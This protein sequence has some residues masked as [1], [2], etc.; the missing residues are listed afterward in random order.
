MEINNKDVVV[1]EPVLEAQNIIGTLMDSIY[2]DGIYQKYLSNLELESDVSKKKA[3]IIK[4]TF[5]DIQVFNSNTEPLFLARDIGILMGITNI[6]STIKNYNKTEKIIGYIIQKGIP[7]EKQLLTRYGVY[8]ILFNS[9]TKLSELFRG[10]IYKLLDHM[11]QHE[12]DKL[13]TII[14]DYSMDNQDL[15]KGSI[16][17]LYENANQF[18]MLYENEKRERLIWMDKAEEE[19]EKN[20]RLEHEKDDAEISYAYD[21]MLIRQLQ[22]DNNFFLKKIHMVRNNYIDQA[23]DQTL[24]ISLK[25]T[26]LK[27]INIFIAK[28]K[29]V[30]KLL[31]KNGVDVDHEE[32]EKYEYE[33]SYVVD[34][35]QRD[36]VLSGNIELYYNIAF[37]SSKDDDDK[38]THMC[39]EWVS[40]KTKFKELLQILEKE[41]DIIKVNNAKN[42]VYIFKT[43]LDNIKNII[44]GFLI[45]QTPPS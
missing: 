19:H 31:K 35:F 30:E 41:S 8:R 37:K 32:T 9:R 2:N 29:Y 40:D 7:K 14:N 11:F 38:Y 42:D 43:T 36:T 45:I 25:K 16:L 24:L 26:F 3:D 10:F 4:K 23:E 6:S 28:P 21:E 13:R 12:I 5:N 17:E 34:S 27:E 22:S 15:V 39:T 1:Y 44:R 18:K 33:Y 20:L